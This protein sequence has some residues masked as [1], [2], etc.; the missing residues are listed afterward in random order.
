MVKKILVG[1]MAITFFTSAALAQGIF[2]FVPQVGDTIAAS[3]YSQNSNWLAL[4][5]DKDI[6]DEVDVFYIYPTV[7]TANGGYPIADI[8]DKNMRTSAQQNFKLQGSAFKVGNMFAP[9]YR[10]LD[11]AYAISKGGLRGGALAFYRGVPKTDIIAA[12]DYYI[13]HYNNGRPFILAGHSQGSIMIKE[14]L[15]DYMKEHPE[16]YQR[17]IAAYIIGAPVTKEDYAAHPYLKAA[18]S[19][20]DLGV[21]ISYNTQAPGWD[22]KNPLVLPNSVMI[23]PI[24]WSTTEQEAPAKNN[25]GTIVIEDGKAKKVVG[26]A[27]AKIDYKANALICSTVEI[28]QFSSSQ[29][30]RQFFPLGVY[31]ENDILLYYYNL[32]QNAKD[33]AANYLKT[34]KK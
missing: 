6:K 25:L 24:S 15:F 1:V 17:M 20:A 2:G 4:P 21:I 22:I 10:Q 19:A 18:K 11:V 5:K 13:K 30:L 31:H 3:D 29:A 32:N 27:D 8:N 23:N 9:Y 7:W 34:K 26:I 16:V 33:R 14:I 12:F 28:M